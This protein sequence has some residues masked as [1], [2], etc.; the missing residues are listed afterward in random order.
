[1]T[2]D[3]IRAA[4]RTRLDE[5]LQEKRFLRWITDRNHLVDQLMVVITQALAEAKRG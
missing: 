4:I 5:F 3:E 1:M 2:D